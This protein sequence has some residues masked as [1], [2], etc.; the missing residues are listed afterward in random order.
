MVISEL[1]FNFVYDLPEAHP[2]RLLILTHT[3]FRFRENG[4][5]Q[6]YAAHHA[7]LL[8]PGERVHYGACEEHY[9]NDW[10]I[11]SSDEPYVAHFPLLNR[12]FPV[13][14]SGYCHNLFQLLTWEHT[15]DEL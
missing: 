11:F 4:T 13:P 8:A 15:E 10:I 3:P 7:A 14:D 5:D 12:P 2:H 1:C 9:S 6:I